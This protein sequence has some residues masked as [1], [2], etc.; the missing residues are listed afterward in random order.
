MHYDEHN[1]FSICGASYKPIYRSVSFFLCRKRDGWF[2]SLSLSLSLLCLCLSMSLSFSLFLSPSLSVF[3]SHSP[4]GVKLK[5]SVLF[6]RPHT[7]RNTK[8]LFVVFV[9]CV[10]SWRGYCADRC[11]TDCHQLVRAS[12]WLVSLSFPLWFFAVGE[13]SGQG[14]HWPSNLPA[15][16]PLAL[17][18]YYYY[19]YYYYSSLVTVFCSC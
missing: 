9:R 11:L 14:L 4:P 1:P 5:R 12:F 10:M 18:Y 16:V 17:Y 8:G 3:I 6:V 15:T 2:S 19:Y 13:W 7:C